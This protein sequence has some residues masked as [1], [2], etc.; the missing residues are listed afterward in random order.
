MKK[1]S[2]SHGSGKR[3]LISSVF[4]AVTGI[5]IFILLVLISSAFCMIPES[6]HAFIAPLCIFSVYS[7]AFFSGFAAV[8]RNGSSALLC[9]ALSGVILMLTVWLAS[10]TLGLFLGITT[11][12]ASAFIF[13]LLIVPVSCVGALIGVGQSKD[14][15]KKGKRK[16]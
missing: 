11:S 14:K 13:K 8:K 9:G 16:F 15:K 12:G 3:L 6:P 4:G 7:S 10:A 5:L 1:G 2:S